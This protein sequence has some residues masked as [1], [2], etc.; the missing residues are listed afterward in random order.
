MQNK[1]F[2]SIFPFILIFYSSCINTAE[3]EIILIPDGYIG[4]IDI[5]FNLEGGNS[6]KFEKGFRVYEIPENGILKTQFKT[7]NGVFSEDARQIFYV[8]KTGK[9]RRL[10]KLANEDAAIN[11]NQIQAFSFVVGQKGFDDCDLEFNSVFEFIV[12][13]P[14]NVSLYKPLDFKCEDVK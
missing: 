3:K 5:L 1:I 10:I 11:E 14:K 7:N 9:R 8:D 2:T 4:R 6:P 13:K 12:D